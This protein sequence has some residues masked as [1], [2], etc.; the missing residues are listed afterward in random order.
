L[1]RG[2]DRKVQGDAVTYD[3][4]VRVNA[5]WSM[6]WVRIAW[7]LRFVIGASRAQRLAL[8]GGNRLARVYVDGERL[9]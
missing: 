6:R 3:V 5:R 4:E 8:W 2:G 1:D 9:R 7:A